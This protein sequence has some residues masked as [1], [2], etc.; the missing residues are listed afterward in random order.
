ME[1]VLHFHYTTNNICLVLESTGN[2]ENKLPAQVYFR[3]G[4]CIWIQAI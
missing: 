4:G 3:I 1:T 2:E